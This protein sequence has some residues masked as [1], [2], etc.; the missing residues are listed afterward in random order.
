MKARRSMLFV[1]GDNPAMLS[2][3]FVYKPDSVMFDL[4]D[5]VSP[6]EKDSARLLVFH[7]LGLPAYKDIER[8]VRINRL[9][10]EYGLK[11]LEAAIRG[12]ADVVRLPKTDSADEIHELESHV[13][14]LEKECGRPA[15]ETKLMAAIE[16]ASGVVNAL[17]I[18]TASPR[19][20]AIALAGFD[21]L[22]DM[23]TKRS[24]GS[25]PELFYARAALLHA[26]RAAHIDAFDV[27]Y[28]NVDDDEGF[29]R[30]VQIAKQ[31]GF[32]GK[33]LIHPRQVYLLHRAY[34]PNE[35]ELEYA[36]KV[37][38]A[39]DA[40]HRNGQGVVSLDGKMIDPPVIK[41]AEEVL[42]RADVA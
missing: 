37:I 19:L 2:T 39:A 9:D 22:V 3:A 26:A 6:R 8:V 12:R 20:I 25:E 11:D 42:S 24:G 40:A 5:A 17:S 16:S 13:A 31:L 41:E 1:P 10:S 29:L 32:N 36:K 27:A 4:E 18:A 15:G 7:A 28:G 34:A 35:K 38:A 33:S 21:Y 14:R 23:Q 30:E